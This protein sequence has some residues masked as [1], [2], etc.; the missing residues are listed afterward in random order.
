MLVSDCMIKNV[1][2]KTDKINMGVTCYEWMLK[3]M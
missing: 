3:G 1:C 2:T